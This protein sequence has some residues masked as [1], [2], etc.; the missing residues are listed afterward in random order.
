MEKAKIL[1]VEDE[2][3]I[4]M[5]IESKLQSL[6]YEVTAIVNN[7]EKAI[8]KAE[9]DKPDLILM[10]IRIK[11]EMDGIDAAEEIRNRFC[12]P[13][14]FST[15]YLDQERIE[16][17][18]ITMPFGY[19]LKPIQ[20]R[21]LK[22]TIEMAL[23]VA[24]IDVERRKAEKAQHESQEKYEIAFKTSPDAVNINLLDGTYVDINDGF[25]RLTGYSREE[26]IGKSSTEIGIWAVP[27][28]RK[29]LVE[30]LQKHQFVENLES[31]FTCKD[32]SNKT[33]LMS[34][35]II[36][37]N[38]EPQIL[39]I[40]RDITHYKKEQE[41]LNESEERNRLLFERSNNAIFIVEKNT[42]CYLHTNAAGERLTGRHISEL[43][44]LTTH[45]VTTQQSQKRLSKIAEINAPIDLGEVTYLQP[46][47][48]T[49]I[50][51]LSVIPFN[52]KIAFGIAN[53]ITERKKAEE[54]LRIAYDE[55]ENKVAERTAALQQEIDERKQIEYNL[56]EARKDAEFA[57][58][59][60]SEFLS[61]VS[62]EIRTP[63]HQILSYSKFGVDKIDKVEKEKLLH[64]FSKI[65]T[66]G[67]NLLSLLNDLLDLSKLE[68]G[69]MDYDMRKSDLKQVI[70]NVSNEFTSLANDKGVIL[71]I[72]ESNIQTE[73]VCDE[74]KI[75]QVIRNFLSNAIKFT[76]KDKKIIISIE[77]N[78]LSIG[79]RKTDTGSIPV[80]CLKVIDQGLGIP[81]DELESVFDKFVQSSK[82][83][84]GAGGTGLGLAI[85]KEIIQ[86]HNGK[87]WAENN[88]EGGSTFSFMLPYEQE[89][90]SD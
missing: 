42:G 86:A 73:I 24:K 63:M 29:K 4:A 26:V 62:H 23:Y 27:E 44:H 77:K 17:A 50:A 43:K 14:I 32:G 51:E 9:A 2:A 6:G 83:K 36:N 33:A 90:T 53:D 34:A 18:K 25:T 37:L 54:D 68:S 1:I 19:V 10:D 35:R 76:P 13:V 58:T 60:K 74:F 69:K 8:D 46:N 49:R 75:G 12:I 59:A 47:G 28:E 11:G 40:T 45:E 71:D 70:N 85:C 30:A 5:G 78:K 67:R 20:E 48:S 89:V 87:I 56:L 3:I 16:R 84:T 65:D 52:E 21:D 66:I 7:G 79:Q 39:S 82:T 22:V 15:A 41:K 81:D 57:N 64:Y 80:L 55:L 72:T 31:T 38:N 88:P 61:N